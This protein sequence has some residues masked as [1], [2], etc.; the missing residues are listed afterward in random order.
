MEVVFNDNICE[1]YE[2]FEKTF[3]DTFKTSPYKDFVSIKTI[4]DKTV[5]F[6]FCEQKVFEIKGSARKKAFSISIK[7]DLFD[8][9]K[10]A[11]DIPV[12]FI[13]DNLKSQPTF[14]RV[15]I[16]EVQDLKNFI[17]Y[18]FGFT[19]KYVDK[20]YIPEYTFGCCHEYMKCS[21]AKHC[22]STDYLYSKGCTYRTKLE[23]GIIFYGKNRNI[24]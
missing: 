12:E 13:I 8:D 17:D 19:E 5:C 1:Y 23:S 24:L 14:T 10:T 3:N 16:S 11:G 2:H 15:L 22:V 7:N 18:I 20:I 21:D 6:L 9:I 4:D